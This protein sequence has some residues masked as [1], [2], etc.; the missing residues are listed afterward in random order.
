MSHS[1]M[2]NLRI[3]V[4]GGGDVAATYAG[5]VWLAWA[6]GERCDSG[7]VASAVLASRGWGGVGASAKNGKSPKQLVGAVAG[8]APAVCGLSWNGWMFEWE[9]RVGDAGEFD[10]GVKLDRGGKG[11]RVVGGR[12]AVGALGLGE[13]E[14]GLLR[15]WGR[16]LL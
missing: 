5:G 16:G 1:I 15:C 14:D 4:A 2:A 9:I 7:V 12:A 6:H 8:R 11:R 13:H 10:R 3:G